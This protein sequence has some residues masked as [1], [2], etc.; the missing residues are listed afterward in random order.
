MNTD[1]SWLKKILKKYLFLLPET[2]KEIKEFE[3]SDEL[4]SIPS[5]PKHL[6]NPNAI[7]KKK[8]ENK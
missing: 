4:H 1:E 3:N 5:I 8:N 7:L 6:E 2:E